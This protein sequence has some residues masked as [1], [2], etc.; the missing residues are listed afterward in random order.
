MA[1][2]AESWGHQLVVNQSEGPNRCAN[3]KTGNTDVEYQDKKSVKTKQLLLGE[4]VVTI[5][6]V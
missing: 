4:L 3:V 1:D 5:V 6:T 2:A